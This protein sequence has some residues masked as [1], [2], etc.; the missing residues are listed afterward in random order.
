MIV[1]VAIAQMALSLQDYRI[2]IYGPLMPYVREPAHLF[3][4]FTL[5]VEVDG[6]LRPLQ[7]ERT[8]L[9]DN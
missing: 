5:A 4:S 6:V 7:L 9:V 1:W 2:F 8:V 3:R